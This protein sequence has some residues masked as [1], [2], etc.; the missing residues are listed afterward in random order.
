MVCDH[1]QRGQCIQGGGGVKLP[2]ETDICC[3]CDSIP[4]VNFES[5]CGADCVVVLVPVEVNLGADSDLE[6]KDKT[7]GI[8]SH[9]L[10]FGGL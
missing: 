1:L 6:R 9:Y 4:T 7:R 2:E 8:R 5:D 3:T 10:R